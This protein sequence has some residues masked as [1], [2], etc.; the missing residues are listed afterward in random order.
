MSTSYFKLDRQGDW[1]ELDQAESSLLE[2]IRSD[3]QVTTKNCV[4]MEKTPSPG[5]T[6]LMIAKEQS[7]LWLNIE[8]KAQPPKL[9]GDRFPTPIL[10]K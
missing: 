2:K 7:A 8:V 10:V 1:E 3:C 9:G 4:H 5:S 6:S